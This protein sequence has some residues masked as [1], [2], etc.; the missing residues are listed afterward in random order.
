[1]AEV[2]PPTLVTFPAGTVRGRSRVLAARQSPDGNVALVAAQTPFHPLD[3]S[4]PDQ[5]ADCGTAEIDGVV[6][7]VIDAL[8]GAYGPAG[9]FATGSAIPVKRGDES[10]TWVVVHVVEGLPDPAAAVGRE[11]ILSVDTERRRALSAAH[12]GCHL[13]SLALNEALADRWPSAV[14]VPA[15]AASGADCRT[16]RGAGGSGDTRRT[17]G[18]AADSADLAE[19]SGATRTAVLVEG[20]KPDR[21]IRTDSLGN[22]DF[23]AV[24]IESSRL[25]V[26]ASTDRYRIGKSLRR[27]GFRSDGLREALPRLTVQ[28]NARMTSWVTAD[29]SVRIETGG[30]AL[31]DRR[32]WICELPYA[33]AKI[34]CGGTHLAR[35]GEV[36]AWTTTLSLSQDGTELL[37]VTTP[38]R[39]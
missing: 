7:P 26:T 8:T 14:S 31:T 12:T 37:A 28:I 6:Y 11:V 1:M 20:G 30:P 39:L 33:T 9:E 24:A 3:H 16:E 21:G 5:P 25:D 29:A 22:P 4:W 34:S 27:K 15:Q 13:F 19:V 35:L 32:Q 2:P 17:S 38:K 18:P 36:V 23:D 10:W